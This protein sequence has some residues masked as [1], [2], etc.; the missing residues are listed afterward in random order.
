[1]AMN[2]AVIGASGYTGLELVKLLLA[3]PE[4]EITYVSNSEG[5]VTIDALHPGLKDVMT[6][7]VEKA[8]AKKVAEVADVAF[9][10]LPH[11]FSM[12]FAKEL[13]DLGVKVVDLSADY[14]LSLENYEAYYCEHCD[15]GNLDQAVYGLPEFY[16]E[17]LKSARL[18]ACP[19]CYPTATL[20]GLLPFAPFIEEAVPVFV[21][22]KS[23]VSG[24]GKKCTPT[25]HF[26]TINENMFAYNPLRHRHSPEI[27]EKVEKVTGKALKI[28]FIPHLV[29]LTRGELVSV[30]ATLKQPVTDPMDV[31]EK[32]YGNE[33]FI[34]LRNQPVDVKS[35][36]G[37]HFCDLFAL[38]NGNALFVN[39]AIDNLLRGSSS[40]AVL[41]ANIMCGLPEHMGIPTIAYIP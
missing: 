9:L 17:A 38:V 5:G 32:A 21:D 39:V 18:V 29:P 2:C 3:H 1:M 4:F 31:L 13:I 19:G 23:G 15:P 8:D 28:N 41:N 22:A 12:E 7:D 37:T 25:T 33:L 6:Q 14:R 34:R 27:Q 24:A 40:Q 26:V 11:K 36:S 10:A 35:V 20:L 30:Y 16:R